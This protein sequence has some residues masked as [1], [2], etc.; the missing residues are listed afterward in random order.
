MRS[1][2]AGLGY[3]QGGSGQAWH[4]GTVG[5]DMGHGQPRH[6]GHTHKVP[7]VYSYGPQ[8]AMA[9]LCMR[10]TMLAS[11]ATDDASSVVYLIYGLRSYGLIVMACIV[12]ACIVMA[13]IAMACIV[14]AYK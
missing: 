2:D 9:D 5:A 1:H 14:M 6:R 11:S 10:C 3:G 7:A 13:Y 12:M 4:G 8:M